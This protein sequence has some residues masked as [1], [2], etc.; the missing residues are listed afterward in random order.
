MKWKWVVPRWAKMMPWW[1]G[2]HLGLQTDESAIG[3]GSP[4]KPTGTRLLSCYWRIQG[5]P[6]YAQSQGH[7]E[8]S[9]SRVMM[10]P[11]KP[12]S[13]GS[14]GRWCYF[15]YG[16]CSLWILEKE[17]GQCMECEKVSKNH[18]YFHHS[19][20]CNPFPPH[21]ASAHIFTVGIILHVILVFIVLCSVLSQ[22]L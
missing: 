8:G 17:L 15:Y 14:E 21:H 5:D 16:K 2:L 11:S 18:D 3:M 13:L 4:V 22:I 9:T 19:A 1:L 12:V 20:Y 7:V 10:L 6:A